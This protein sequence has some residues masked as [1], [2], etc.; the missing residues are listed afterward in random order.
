MEKEGAEE[1]EKEPSA[2]RRILCCSH[3]APRRKSKT[4]AAAAA[5][6]AP[7]RRS[8]TRTFQLKDGALAR[9]GTR[10]PTETFLCAFF[11]RDA[12]RV[13]VS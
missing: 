9:G 10:S 13:A 12:A 6:A 11:E 5:F 3:T 1:G 2:S 7:R 8:A 4:S